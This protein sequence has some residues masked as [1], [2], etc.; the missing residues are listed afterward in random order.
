MRA[1]CRPHRFKAAQRFIDHDREWL[2]MPDGAT[3]PT[4]KPVSAKAVAA[5]ANFTFFRLTP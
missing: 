4:S 3:P 1:R 5:S 2:R